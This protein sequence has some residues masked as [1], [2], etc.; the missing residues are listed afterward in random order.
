MLKAKG[1]SLLLKLFCFKK[2][3]QRCMELAGIKFALCD[4]YNKCVI[5]CLVLICYCCYTIMD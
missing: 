5:L 4:T 3:L 2:T 1:E